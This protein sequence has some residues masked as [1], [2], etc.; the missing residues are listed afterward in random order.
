MLPR[1]SPAALISLSAPAVTA[2]VLS[3]C[4]ANGSAPNTLP[5]TVLQTAPSVTLELS[6]PTL[7]AGQSAQLTWTTVNATSCIASGAWNGQQEIENSQGFATVPPAPGTYSYGLTCTGPGGVNSDVKT[8]VVSDASVP[9]VSLTLTPSQIRPGDSATLTWA[10][11]EASA[12]AASGGTGTDGWTG[13]RDTSNTAGFAIGP[14]GAAGQ[15][16]YTLS[17]TGPGGTADD[18]RI[19]TVSNSAPAAPPSITFSAT[20]ATIQVGGTPSLTWNSQNATACTGTGGASGDNWGGSEPLS[21]SGTLLSPLTAAGGFVYTLTCSG[22]GGSSS[23][24]TS[25]VVTS[26]PPSGSISVSL[27][28]NP[29]TIT[30]GSSSTLTWSS[31]GGSSCQASG[32]WTGTQPTG[33]AGFGIG[34]LNTPGTYSYSLT[35]SGS[36]GNATGTAVL[37]VNPTPPSLN[38]F[39]AASTTIQS[40]QAPTLMWS[41]DYATGC[42]ASGGT[43]SDGWNG[44]MSAN[45]AGTTLTPIN[46]PG[47]YVYILACSGDGGQ[48]GPKSVQITVTAPTPSATVTA[49]S[50]T[51]SQVAL[52]GSYSLTWSTANATSCVASGGSGGDGWNGSM[53]VSSSGFNIGPISVAGTYTYTITCSGPGGASPPASVSVSVATATPPASIVAFTASPNT[54]QAG[55]TVSLSWSTANA[56]SCTAGNG[57]G[58]D[59]WNGTLATSSS[60]TNIGPLGTAGSFIY[61]LSCTGPG[62]TSSQA[63]TT[64]TV[65]PAPTPP[66]ITTLAASP[67]HIITGESTVLSWS[68]VGTTG[69]VASGGT[70]SDGW[71]GPIATTSAGTT[72]GP[73]GQAGTY[74]YSISCTGPGGPAATATVSVVVSPAPVGPP[75]ITFTA[76]G[77]N[78]TQ[79]APSGALTLQ[80]STV[81]ATACSAAGGT[82]SDGWSGAEA[83]SS[84]GF[85]LGTITSPGIYTYTLSCSGPGG[86]TTASV[87]VTVIASAA[88]DCGI[89]VP[90][91]ALIAPTASIASAVNGF[92]LAGCSITNTA[93]I[94]DPDLT[95]YATVSVAL[96][97]SAYDTVKV[98]DAVSTYPAGRRVGFLISKPGLLSLTLLG[99]LTV[100]TLLN[101]SA[102]ETATASTLLQLSALG[103]FV[104][105]HE[106]FVS[107]ATTKPFNAVQ[108]SLGS[109]AGVSSTLNVYAACVTLQ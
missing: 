97:V 62:G 34:P 27:S 65:T 16:S 80:W 42:T 67:N 54:V 96:G 33:G 44:A 32:S 20:P 37:T 25:V 26:G 87:V 31:A 77:T 86:S 88:A 48:S 99:N 74:S 46:N 47:T 10:T 28:V 73:I 2:L 39:A 104:D 21:S 52:N 90:S 50:A 8:L 79:V 101:G 83:T 105:P 71:A 63:S 7:T 78:P 76:N 4:T 100:K 107:F 58:S 84:T 15:Y 49:F 93:N 82:G 98:S 68:T 92:C 14:F 43:G 55:Q 109:L 51:P 103:A 5:T 61:S 30:A 106:G 57:S 60:G 64:V 22:P 9:N 13:S 1:F 35:C 45:S 69:C 3:A 59:G 89:G 41:S 56:T 95:D 70:G 19:L 18:T 81:N 38:T 40:G 91:T 6:S 72:V 29:S 102:Q 12:C 23:T 66:A 17:C 11:S 85:S 75:A 36:G 53:A 24:N 94:I 108:L